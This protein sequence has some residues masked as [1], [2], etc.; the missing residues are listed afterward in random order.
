M[1]L[2]KSILRHSRRTRRKANNEKVT[3]T[4]GMRGSYQVRLTRNQTGQPPAPL[5]R[6]R[7]RLDS[8]SGHAHPQLRLKQQLLV[9][10][11]KRSQQMKI[12]I[13]NRGFRLGRTTCYYGTN[14]I[15]ISLRRVD[16]IEDLRS[17]CSC[18][19]DIKA[20]VFCIS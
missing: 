16:G 1:K 19:I 7:L 20:M 14:W 11:L 2:R 10:G 9:R 15:L 3:F 17:V 6:A 5:L 4:L 12:L 18:I 13:L 8:G